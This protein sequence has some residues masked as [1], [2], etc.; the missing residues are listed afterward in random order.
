M[1]SSAYTQAP[2]HGHRH[3]HTAVFLHGRGSNAVEFA[4]ELFESEASA[5]MDSQQDGQRTLPAL[6]P[7][8][9]WVFPTAPILRSRRFDTDMSQWFDMWSVK[10]P[11]EHSEI[12][13][14][15]LGQ[16][17]QRLL[18]IIKTEEQLVP[19]SRIF[20]CGIS[21]GFATVLS[22]L[23]AEG[24]GGFAGLIGLCSWIPFARNVEQGI[25]A[26]DSLR[27]H[28]QQVISLYSALQD[29][30][31]T[32][33]G[34]GRV[35]AEPIPSQIQAIP[36]FL[37]HA[38]DDT[39]VPVENARR[40]QKVLSELGLSVSWREYDHGGHWVNE[41]QGVDDIVCFLS[42]YMNNQSLAERGQDGP[43]FNKRFASLQ[44]L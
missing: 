36:V 30:Y 17:I 32:A 14:D 31:Y 5:G 2:A 10:D 1:S 9:R 34:N 37:G 39:V 44:L 41:P 18:G 4:S 23:L 28:V 7:T 11:E 26:R 43:T 16:S 22:T 15:G 19:R 20:L 3:T 21:Q 12:Q 29:L 42:Y 24:Q 40:L 13:H 6:F 25:A 38:L 35:K 8:V 33:E 27:G